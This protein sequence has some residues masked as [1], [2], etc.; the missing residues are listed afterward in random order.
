MATKPRVLNDL[1]ALMAQ[2][3]AQ[4]AEIEALKA[5]QGTTKEP[6]VAVITYTPKKGKN[7]GVPGKRLNVTGNFFP[8]V[9]T[10]EQCKVI[11]S[12]FKALKSFADVGK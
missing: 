6:G 8:L 12:N 9:L 10:Q 2:L 7:A 3:E 11:S 1:S 5:S 4:K